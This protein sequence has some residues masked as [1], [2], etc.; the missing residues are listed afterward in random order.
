MNLSH[1]FLDVVQKPP[2]LEFDI[3]MFFHLAG[4]GCLYIPDVKAALQIVANIVSVCLIAISSILGSKEV[5][6]S[7][8]MHGQAPGTHFW[9]LSACGLCLP[10]D[11]THPFLIIFKYDKCHMPGYVSPSKV[12]KVVPCD[13][14]QGRE[15][16]MLPLPRWERVNDVLLCKWFHMMSCHGE[17]AC[18]A[19]VAFMRCCGHSG[20]GMSGYDKPHSLPGC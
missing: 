15:D 5:Y 13:V 10:E 17:I 11:E 20:Q 9:P 2:D 12:V 14:V 4:I 7:S 3:D 1:E 18:S 19:P 16:Q 8:S 6:A